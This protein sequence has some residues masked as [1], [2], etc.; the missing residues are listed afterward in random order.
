MNLDDYELEEADW[1]SIDLERSIY[2][3]PSSGKRFVDFQT[4]RGCPFNCGFCY[5]KK[6]ARRKMRRFS[7]EVVERMARLLVEKYQVDCVKFVDDNIY[8]QRK[9][10]FDVLTRLNISF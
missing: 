1:D 10:L 2:V 3:D 5:N 9:R 4:S 6:F 8:F 7:T